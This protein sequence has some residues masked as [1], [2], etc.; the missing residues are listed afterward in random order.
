MN[1][2]C[3]QIS[4][5]THKTLLFYTVLHFNQGLNSSVVDPDPHTSG[6]FS[7]KPEFLF[8]IRIQQKMKDQLN[9]NFISTFKPVNSKLCTIGLQYE[10]ENGS[11]LVYSSS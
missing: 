1:L 7:R 11:Q 8:R 3:V 5:I 4:T 10:K 6:T 9:K 2:I